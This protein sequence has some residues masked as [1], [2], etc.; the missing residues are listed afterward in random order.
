[1]KKLLCICRGPAGSGKTFL[2]KKLV[3]NGQIFSTDDYWY[4]KD[5][6]KYDFDINKLGTAHTWNRRRR[7]KAVEVDV[8]PIIIDNTNVTLKELRSF[9][10]II[11]EAIKKGYEIE[12]REPDT[13]W[14]FDIDELD[15]RNSHNVPRETIEKMLNKYVKV[16][17]LKD[18]IG[19]VVK[20]VRDEN[21]SCYNCCSIMEGLCT[22][23]K[24]EYFIRKDY[25]LDNNDSCEH[26]R[27]DHMVNNFTKN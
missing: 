23:N 20:D 22:N 1:M 11:L 2:A 27:R 19:D 10:N 3:K 24:S 4:I 25:I 26:W 12:I 8:N 6:N 9:K 16:V 17:T 21:S 14:K 18:I 15:K 5:P 13:W 7:E